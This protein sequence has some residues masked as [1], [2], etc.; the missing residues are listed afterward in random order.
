M[1]DFDKF[2]SNLDKSHDAV[3]Q[4]ARWLVSRG[5][6]VT[7]NTTSKASSSDELQ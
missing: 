1:S 5:N 6:K 7:I 4:V 3:W 2:I